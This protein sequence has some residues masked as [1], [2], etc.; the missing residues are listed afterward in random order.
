[1]DKSFAITSEHY[2]SIQLCWCRKSSFSWRWVSKLR[3]CSLIVILDSDLYFTCTAENVPINFT[4]KKKSKMSIKL[5]IALRDMLQAPL[6][7]ALCFK[8]GNNLQASDAEW[9]ASIE[10]LGQFLLWLWR[11]PGLGRKTPQ[12][13]KYRAVGQMGSPIQKEKLNAW[14]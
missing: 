10:L 2:W 5:E 6:V 9:E 12:S 13:S 11:R 3:F 7:G 14:N 1:M 4:L 8:A